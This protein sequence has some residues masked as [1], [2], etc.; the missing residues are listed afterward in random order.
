[1]KTPSDP[2]ANAEP[3]PLPLIDSPQIQAQRARVFAIL[4]IFPT[5]GAILILSTSPG[6]PKDAPE[7]NTIWE[8]IQSVPVERWIASGIVLGHLI[9][10]NRAFWLWR[11]SKS[12]VPPV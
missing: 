4:W 2:S 7:P 12:D 5:L 11:E 1:V 10:A 8:L 9:A 3:V 6:R